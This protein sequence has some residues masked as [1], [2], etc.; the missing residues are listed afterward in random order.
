MTLF[1]PTTRYSYKSWRVAPAH[2]TIARFRCQSLWTRF[3]Y[4]WLSK[5][6]TN[7][8]RLCIYNVFSHLLRT[9]AVVNR[10]QIPSPSHFKAKW[11]FWFPVPCVADFVTFYEN[12]SVHAFSKWR[13][14]LGICYHNADVVVLQS[15][16]ATLCATFLTKS[17][18]K[19]GAPAAWVTG[20]AFCRWQESRLG[21]LAPNTS[22]MDAPRVSWERRPFH[23][24]FLKPILGVG[25]AKVLPVNIS[26]KYMPRLFKWICV[27]LT[28]TMSIFKLRQDI[29][30]VSVISN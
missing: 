22:N 15:I 2:L 28:C 17:I 3:V 4:L 24:T 27:V 16:S 5:L 23:E 10:I 7:E 18:I 25:V 1:P 26:I 12:I 21:L 29:V 20:R 11:S 9:C 13:I 14:R 30:N 19:S 8:R 6:S